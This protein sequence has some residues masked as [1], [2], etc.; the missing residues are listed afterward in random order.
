MHLEGL[1]STVSS[2]GGLGRSPSRNWIWC[3]LALKSDIWAALQIHDRSPKSR[4][5]ASLNQSQ[6]QMTRPVLECNVPLVATYLKIF[7]RIKWPNFMQ[8]FLILFRIWKRV[9]T[10]YCKALNCDC[11]WT[12]TVQYGS[13]IQFYSRWMISQVSSV[14]FLVYTLLYVE[15]WSTDS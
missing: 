2:P 8:N 7:L 6:T 9:N 5:V 1:G 12:V 14:S 10:E 3:I 11:H 15:S 4:P 13:S